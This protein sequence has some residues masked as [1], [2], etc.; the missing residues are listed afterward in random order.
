MKDIKLFT[1]ERRQNYHTT[2]FFTE[3][4]LAMEMKKRD[5]YE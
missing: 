5:T 4:V 1:I 3:Y 2:R